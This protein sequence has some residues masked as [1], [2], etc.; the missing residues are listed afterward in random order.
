M[1]ENFELVLKD[2]KMISPRVRHLSFTRTDNQ[3][4]SFIAGQFISFH[5]QKHDKELLRNYSIASMPEQTG[6]IDIACA[7]VEHGLASELLFNLQPGDTVKASGVYGRFYLKEEPAKRY[8]LIATGTG[9]TPYRSML[10]EIERR[11]STS[12]LEVVVIMG[13]RSQ[14]E[15]LYNDEFL[16][17]AEKHPKFKYLACYSRIMPEKPFEYER[18]GHVQDTFKFLQINSA[19]DIAYLCGHP[20]MVDSCFSILQELGLDKKNIRREKYVF[21]VQA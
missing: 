5:I 6:V 21:G 11:L 9:V 10:N 16:T 15:L 2:Y 8:L 3:P 18:S 19:R 1:A 7:Y 14:E 17:F 20:D 12:D 13:G 4:L